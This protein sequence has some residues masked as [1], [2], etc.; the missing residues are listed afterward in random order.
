[1][2]NESD[3]VMKRKGCIKTTREDWTVRSGKGGVISI[4]KRRPSDGEREANRLREQHCRWVA[5]TPDCGST[6]SSSSQ[7]TRT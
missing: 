1:M 3:V 4:S 5:K 6:V 2:G 7:S